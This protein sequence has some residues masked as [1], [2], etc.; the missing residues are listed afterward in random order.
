MRQLASGGLTDR[1]LAKHPNGSHVA[2]ERVH[3]ERARDPRFVQALVADVNV[4][5]TLHHPN[6]ARVYEAGTAG[7]CFV[8]AEWVHGADLRQI[9]AY[10]AAKGQLLPVEHALTIAIAVASALGDAHARGVVHGDIAPA[11]IVVGFDGT[12]KVSGFGLA[13]AAHL[14]R[15][16]QPGA[17]GKVSYMSPEQAVG[18]AIDM[19]SDIYAFGIVLYELVTARR[20]FKAA[21][22]FLA[23]TALLHGEIPQPSKVR[24]GLAT[25]L[26]AIIMRALDRDPARRFQAIDELRVA[27]AQF[28]AARHVRTS[29]AILADHLR[30]VFGRPSEPW[31]ADAIDD[32]QPG[33]VAVPAPG[34]TATPASGDEA[35]EIVAPLPLDLLEAPITAPRPSRRRRS[36]APVIALVTVAALAVTAVVLV[37]GLGGDDD[38]RLRAPV[39]PTLEVLPVAV[40]PPVDAAVEAVVEEVTPVV[41]EPAPKPP[42]VVKKKLK[43]SKRPLRRAP[44]PRP[45]Q[46]AWDRD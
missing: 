39:P 42:P 4:A 26:D 2:L 7:E 32:A 23:M 30:K 27:L 37:I 40:P 11:N 46:P 17:K 12:V 10:A 35:T 38:P 41:A 20:L 44:K 24:G 19:R 22:D 43:K 36:R 33:I 9:L 3:G 6:I 25:E 31:I 21:N 14:T 18:G 15:E 34:P 28:C 5:A 45:A 29:P 1:W 16:T 8:A 13:K